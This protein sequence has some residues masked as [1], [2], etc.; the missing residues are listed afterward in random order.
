VDFMT[1]V[2]ARMAVN[3]FEQELYGLQAEY[4]QLLA[5]LEMAIGR[6]LTEYTNGTME[7]R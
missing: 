6:E 4:G 1:L 3:E 7:D 2:D 5:E